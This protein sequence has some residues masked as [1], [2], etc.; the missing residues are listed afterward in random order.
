MKRSTMVTGVV[1]LVIGVAV[2]VLG[3][4]EAAQVLSRRGGSRANGFVTDKQ[5]STRVIRGVS[6][7]TYGIRYRFEVDGATY[8]AGDASGR[9]DLAV[10]I[11]KDRWDEFAVGDQVEVV[12]EPAN[13]ANNRPAPASSSLSDPLAGLLV[14]LVLC[15]CGAVALA[16]ARQPKPVSTAPVHPATTTE[17]PAVHHVTVVEPDV[18]PPDADRTVPVIDRSDPD[19]VALA[20]LE[21]RAHLSGGATSDEGWVVRYQ[22]GKFVRNSWRGVVESSEVIDGAEIRRLIRA[23]GPDI[24]VPDYLD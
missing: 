4:R 1:L 11:P 12:F 8:T 17:P 13:P 16:A 24:V 20:L 5:M 18:R 2:T 15:A 3:A 23:H 22:D 6:V 9:T 10:G 7:P 19:A 21:G 14:G